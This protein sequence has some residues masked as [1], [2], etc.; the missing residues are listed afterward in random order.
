M[1]H[2]FSARGGVVGIIHTNI[3]WR[4]TTHTALLEVL[5]IATFKDIHL[6]EV[7]TWVVVVVNGTIPRTQVLCAKNRA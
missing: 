6:R 4:L 1:V 2:V 3:P 7:N 5:T